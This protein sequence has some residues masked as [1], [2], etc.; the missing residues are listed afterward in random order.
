M[1]F[2][3]LVSAVLKTTL[4]NIK[5]AHVI[6]LNAFAELFGGK[7]L[8]WNLFQVVWR[9]SEETDTAHPVQHYP[10]RKEPIQP[11]RHHH[12]P[13]FWRKECYEKH[14]IYKYKYRYKHLCTASSYTIK[15]LVQTHLEL[16]LF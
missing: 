15:S 3:W 11:N 7:Q 4:K 12:K 1:N 5:T 9:P 14:T 13:E 6:I 8:A 16:D 10:D 2:K